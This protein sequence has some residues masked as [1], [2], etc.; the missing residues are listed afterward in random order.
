[1]TKL[2]NYGKAIIPEAKI[3]KYLLCLEHEDGV[4]KAK[5]FGSSV[6]LMLNYFAKPQNP[7]MARILP[8]FIG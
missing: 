8:E 5:F 7:D 2:P 1:M 3:T 4:S 6:L